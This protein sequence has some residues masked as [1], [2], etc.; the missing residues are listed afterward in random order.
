MH[1]TNRSLTEGF[2]AT[3]FSINGWGLRYDKCRAHTPGDGAHPQRLAMPLIGRSIRCGGCV[4]MHQ[5][6]D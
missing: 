1:V 5:H 6:E 4:N 2:Y 3:Q